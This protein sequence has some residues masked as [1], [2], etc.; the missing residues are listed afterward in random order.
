MKH[1]IDS[2]N[3]YKARSAG[4]LKNQQKAYIPTVVDDQIECTVQSYLIDGHR[5]IMNQTKQICF[6]LKYLNFKPMPPRK[7]IKFKFGIWPM[8]YLVEEDVIF[9]FALFI[10]GRFIPWQAIQLAIGQE[11]YYLVVNFDELSELKEYTLKV[12]YA[13]IMHIP[14]TLE[15]VY[16]DPDDYLNFRDESIVALGFAADGSFYTD[17]IVSAFIDNASQ[18]SHIVFDWFNTPEEVDAF[19]FTGRHDVKLSEAN[20]VL[21]KNNLLATGN[22]SPIVIGFDNEYMNGD[23]CV[24]YIDK[25]ISDAVIEPNPEIKFDSTLLTINGGE[26]PNNDD[27]TFGIFINTKYAKSVDNISRAELD[28]LQPLIQDQNSGV[29]NPQY[30]QDLQIPFEFSMSREKKY[31]VNVSEAIKTILTYNSS[32]FNSVYKR[33]SNLIIE[34]YTGTEIN[35]LVGENGT[36]EF[37]RQHNHMIQEF[38]VMFVNG[39]VYKYHFMCKNGTNRFIVPV[40]GINDD[41]IVELFRFKHICN[42]EGEI[43]INEDDG[44]VPYAEEIINE[45]T[46]LFCKETHED[47]YEYP[48]NGLQHFPVE[49]TY[50]RD[51]QNNVKFTLAEPFYYGK[52]LY[53]AYKNRFI[54]KSIIMDETVTEKYH[55]D[56]GNTFMY[57]NDYSKF[58]IFQNG[59]RLGSDHYRLVLPVRAGTPFSTFEIYLT[60]P[61]TAG[62]RLDIMY[63]PSLMQ[64]VVMMDSLPSSGD[65]VLDK[66]LLNYGISTDLY[67]VWING[68]KIPR[69]HIR[70]I[71]STHMRIIS[72][73]QSTQTVCITKYIPDIDVFTEVFKNNEALWDNIMKQL[74][75]EEIYTLLGISGA[76]LTNTEDSIYANALPVRSVMYELIRKHFMCNPRVDVTGPFAYDYQDVDDTAIDGYDSGD[77][78]LLPT[79]DANTTDNL[80]IERSEI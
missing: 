49:F 38:I 8:L 74:T 15:Y 52:K 47:H 40:Q 63:I 16:T 18:N 57:C 41:D 51:V 55:L 4:P 10:N 62:D 30:L 33:K 24:T 13:Q 54:H 46:V 45:N 61:V 78:A 42:F 79:G 77:N 50:E 68:K 75:D 80:N 6:K 7:S 20:V 44:F 19:K 12:E 27:Y 37:S 32:L 76:E 69:S 35:A 23:V 67:M 73:E 11:N 71:D 56:L 2:I 14:E 36:I 17:T 25:K 22:K 29:S 21:F 64:D 48:A 5:T 72:D 70:D 39:E 28:T 31:D 65:I 60:K 34:E 9:P 26:N 53:I 43:V 59:R 1:I 66:S 58:F 3:S